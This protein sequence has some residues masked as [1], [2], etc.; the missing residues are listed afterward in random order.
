LQQQRKGARGAILKADTAEAAREHHARPPRNPGRLSHSS[1]QHMDDTTIR[2]IA[3]VLEWGRFTRHAPFATLRGACTQQQPHAL[4]T[5][6]V[7]APYEAITEFDAALI[8]DRPRLQAFDQFDLHRPASA[9][10][11]AS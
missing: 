7:C 5:S 8:G 2:A 10:A 1:A 3:P 11:G 4:L 6:T 9:G